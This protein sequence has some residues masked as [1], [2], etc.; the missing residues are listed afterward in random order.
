[1]VKPYPA[2]TTSSFLARLAHA[3]QLAADSLRFYISGSRSHSV[4][5]PAGRLAAAAGIPVHVLR[6]AIPD[7]DLDP[8]PYAR[9]HNGSGLPQRRG[10]DGLAC[11]LCVLARGISEPVLCWK[12]PENVICLRHRRWIWSGHNTDQPDLSAQPDVLQAHRRHLRLVRRYGRDEVAIEYATADHICRKWHE[13]GRHDVGFRER[14]QIFHGPAW[15][16]RPTDPTFAAAIY[17]QAVA[18]TRLLVSPYWHSL[19]TSGTG[20]GMRRFAEE[21][22]RTVAPGYVWPQPSRPADPLEGWVT[23]R[24]ISLPR[25]GLLTYHS[26]PVTEE[27]RPRRATVTSFGMTG[28]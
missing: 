6:Y 1:M 28:T 22:C 17:P 13:R 4:P 16:V 8:D 20:A 23:E 14:M 18:L 12:R 5:V 15:R 19:P 2:E 26:W 10:D 21:V 3:N 24:R 25:P 9:Y 27:D 11:R 7:L